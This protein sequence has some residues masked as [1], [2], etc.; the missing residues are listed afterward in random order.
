MKCFFAG[1]GWAA[2]NV[3]G[4]GTNS[5]VTEPNRDCGGQQ[6]LDQHVRYLVRNG[7]MSSSADTHIV[8]PPLE[9][10]SDQRGLWLREITTT[11]LTEDLSPVTMKFMIPWS[12]VI[13]CG[14]V[15]DRPEKVRLGFDVIPGQA[16]E[17]P[18]E[19]LH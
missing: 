6:G 5:H 3:S 10:A 16:Q 9:D 17:R 12:F 13:A 14:L 15:D 11:Q 18:G 19:P 7:K 1:R 2:D 4:G 8:I